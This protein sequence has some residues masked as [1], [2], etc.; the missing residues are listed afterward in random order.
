ML[1]SWELTIEAYP[2][3]RFGFIDDPDSQ[4]GNGS[5]SARTQT[6]SDGPERLLTWNDFTF[7][8]GEQSRSTAD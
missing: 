1:M 7:C 8:K 2:S 3:G 5:V 6:R 4:F